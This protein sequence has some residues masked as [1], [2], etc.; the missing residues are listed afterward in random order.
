MLRTYVDVFQKHTCV[1][2]SNGQS[3]IVHY[4]YTEYLICSAFHISCPVYP[5]SISGFV[6]GNDG[7]ETFNYLFKN[8]VPHISCT[9]YFYFGFHV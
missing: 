9:I 2:N 3:E 4:T 5:I 6:C 7:G 8:E 1:A